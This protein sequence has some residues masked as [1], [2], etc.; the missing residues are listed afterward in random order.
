MT[1]FMPV[2]VVVSRADIPTA[3][4]SGLSF[5]PWMNLS[6]ETSMPRSTTSIPAPCAIIFTRFL[7]MSWRSPFTVPKEHLADGLHARL[8]ELG[9]QDVH[10]LVHRPGGDQDLRDVDLVCFEAPADLFHSVQK[11]L[12]EH[13][14][15]AAFFAASSPVVSSFALGALPFWIASESSC[16]VAMIVPP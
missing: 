7:P 10:A 13:V 4:A 11:T 15:R 3:F 12:V 6:A 2:I 1:S 14:G 9:L 16:T 8:H 5:R